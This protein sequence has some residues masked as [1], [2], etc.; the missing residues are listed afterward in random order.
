MTAAEKRS[1]RNAEI[2]R[3]YEAGMRQDEIAATVHRC[4]STVAATIAAAGMPR[5]TRNSPRPSPSGKTRKSKCKPP[6]LRRPAG[7][8]EPG[9]VARL[10]AGR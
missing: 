6:N 5:H 9:L 4:Q 8:D 2:C 10:T 1:A 7:F 3:L